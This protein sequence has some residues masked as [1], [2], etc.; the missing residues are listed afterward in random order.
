[1][2]RT[3]WLVLAPCAIGIT[4]AGVLV[5]QALSSPTRHPFGLGEAT[6]T[7]GVA[8]LVFRL[9][10]DFSRFRR[11]DEGLVSNIVSLC[12]ALVVVL[13]SLAWVLNGVGLAGIVLVSAALLAIPLSLAA[14]ILWG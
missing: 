6:L 11:T 1:M 10:V 12:A 14:W 5:G 7:F 3:R 8:C 2:R 4:I 13:V 9:C